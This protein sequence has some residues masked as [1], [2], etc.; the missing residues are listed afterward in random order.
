[1]KITL[2]SQVSIDGKITLGEGASSKELFSL[3]TEEDM[4]FIHGIR[5]EVDGILVGMNTIRYDNPSLTCRYN[6]GKNPIRIIP[7]NSMNVPK[8]VTI[9]KDNEKTIFITNERNREK[10][11]LY[12]EC[13]NISCILCGKDK[14]DIVQAFEILEK[15]YHINHI[16]LEGGGELNWSLLEL[17][18]I[19]EVIV[20]Q[21]PILIG[22]RSNIS[23]VDGEGFHLMEK[24]PKFKLKSVEVRENISINKYEKI[25]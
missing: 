12:N 15:E 11:E 9:V 18:L 4:K 17:G 10:V 1:M 25:K 23:L 24:I 19:D 8:D 13:D 2:V 14:L 16:M 22:G 21:L 6:G 20:M 7:T 3:L 5:G